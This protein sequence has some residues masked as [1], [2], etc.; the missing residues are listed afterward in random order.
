MTQYSADEL[1]QAK[2]EMVEDA[3]IT[4]QTRHGNSANTSKV[5]NILDGQRVVEGHI[6]KNK[7]TIIFDNRFELERQT[8]TAMLANN[9]ISRLNASLYMCV[10]K[11]T[12]L[13]YQ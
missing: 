3:I 6:D 4:L 2:G 5:I 10:A 11:R 13:Q 1:A 8:V 7:L 9:E 12:I